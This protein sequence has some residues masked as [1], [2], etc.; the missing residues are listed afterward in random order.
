M[1]SGFIFFISKRNLSSDFHFP[2]VAGEAVGDQ[3]A[4]KFGRYQTDHRNDDHA[5]Y[6]GESTR[7]DG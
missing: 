5:A 4:V 6:H 7:V 2:F 1:L 3:S